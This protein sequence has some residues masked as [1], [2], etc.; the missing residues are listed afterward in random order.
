[1]IGCQVPNRTPA[2]IPGIFCLKDQPNPG[3][4]SGLI[5]IVANFIPAPGITAL[6]ENVNALYLPS[7]CFTDRKIGE[8]THYAK[9]SGLNA[10]VLH[11]K[12]PHGLIRW[13][14]NHNLAKEI[15]AVAANGL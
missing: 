13:K 7:H 2:F 3:H 8:F 5:F 15:G 12:D 14:S 6:P 10:A 11:V 9:L 4:E 1:M